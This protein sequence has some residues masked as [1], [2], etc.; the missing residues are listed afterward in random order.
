M[1]GMSIFRVVLALGIGFSLSSCS[2][3]EFECA[4]N[5]AEA[6]LIEASR[7]EISSK[8]SNNLKALKD[9]EKSSVSF[10]PAMVDQMVA[11]LSYAVTAASDVWE[12]ETGDQKSCRARLAITVDRAHVK[13]ADDARAA[14]ELSNLADLATQSAVEFDGASKLTQEIDFS[15]NL[16]DEGSKIRADLGTSFTLFDVVGELGAY[17]LLSGEI[18][19]TKRDAEMRE[20]R[21]QNEQE[22]A[23]LDMARAENRAAIKAIG[24]IWS[25][26]ARETRSEL[27]ALQK[28]W[29]RK[30]NADCQ[31]ESLATGGSSVDI[32]VNQLNCDTRA[33]IERAT[34]LRGH[35]SAM[36]SDVSF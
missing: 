18:V 8:I 24:A 9:S 5:D 14:L 26:L 23:A 17:S 35:L 11:K 21:A 2:K 31:I 19:K 1:T 3:V 16:A 33:Q 30:K 20:Q 32:Q 28:A 10:T 15:L 6:A 4:S 34:W 22:R 36:S 12:N 29:I 13:R 27:A 25:A 7:K